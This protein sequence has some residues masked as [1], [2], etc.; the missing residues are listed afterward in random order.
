ISELP[1][2]VENTN[3]A[4]DD[5]VSKLGTERQNEQIRKN[6]VFK[7]KSY[8][9]PFL[10]TLEQLFHNVEPINI[11]RRKY[12]KVGKALNKI[13]PRED[14]RRNNGGQ[15]LP[16]TKYLD[17]LIIMGLKNKI[18]REHETSM[19]NWVYNFGL[20][21]EDRKSTRLNS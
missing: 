9:K 2:A 17:A 11:S 6:K 19:N 10:K 14:G 13:A 15:E 21:S 16:H 1:N 7:D 20:A 12:Y 3:I 4:R 18:F 5:A 8:D